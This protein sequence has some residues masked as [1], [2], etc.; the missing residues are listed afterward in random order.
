MD[1]ATKKRIEDLEEAYFDLTKR[2]QT[3]VGEP[4]RMLLQI[5]ELM[6]KF[7]WKAIEEPPELREVLAT[8]NW[9]AS[10]F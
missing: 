10:R 1:D 2:Y 6:G 5:K 3:E 8:L 4:R 9:A 7:D